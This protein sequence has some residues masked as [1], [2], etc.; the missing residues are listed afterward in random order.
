[1][2]ESGS[3]YTDQGRGGLSDG[4]KGQGARHQL[5]FRRASGDGG[6]WGE[7]VGGA[8]SIENIESS[9]GSGGKRSLTRSVTCV[10]FQ[11]WMGVCVGWVV[12]GATSTL[13]PFRSPNYSQPYYKHH[14]E[15]PSSALQRYGNIFS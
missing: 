5:D 3:R 15:H 12:V 11:G 9:W 10:T 8:N 2:G 13:T 7:G 14:Q 6:V 1:M 4:G